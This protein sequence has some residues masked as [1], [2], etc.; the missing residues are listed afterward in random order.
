MRLIHAVV[1][2]ERFLL[3]ILNDGRTVD[4]Y[5]IHLSSRNGNKVAACELTQ[6]VNK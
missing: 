4:D 3:F 5:Y 2:R 6:I 1:D